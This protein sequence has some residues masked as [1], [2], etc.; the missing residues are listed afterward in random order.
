VC[1]CNPYG[2]TAVGVPGR[3]SV[4]PLHA[5]GCPTAMCIQFDMGQ[6]MGAGWSNGMQLK[7]NVSWMY[8]HPGRKFG[9]AVATAKEIEGKFCLGEQAVPQVE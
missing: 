7:S 1:F 2:V 9:A 6:D 8:M 4:L 5:V 3:V